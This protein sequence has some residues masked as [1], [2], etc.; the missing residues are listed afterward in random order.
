MERRAHP[1]TTISFR[2]HIANVSESIPPEVEVIDVSLGGA[3]VAYDEPVGLLVGERVVVSLVPLDASVLLLGRV[4]RVARGSDFRTYVAV[5]FAEHQDD[6]IGRLDT[7][8]ERLRRRRLG[9]AA[10]QPTGVTEQAQDG[11]SSSSAAAT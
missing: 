1:R 11:S 7:E 3:L 4:V 10:G 6:E 9:E 5:E 8:L 2:A